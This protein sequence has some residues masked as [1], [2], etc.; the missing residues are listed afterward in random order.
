MNRGRVPE[1]I[2]L[3]W[4]FLKNMNRTMS[5]EESAGRDH[6]LIERGKNLTFNEEKDLQ[7][8]YR[9]GMNKDEVEQEPKKTVVAGSIN[10]HSSFLSA[11]P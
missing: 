3:S 5:H 6:A 8:D 9:K 11:S 1:G 2:G 4:H 10:C 7:G